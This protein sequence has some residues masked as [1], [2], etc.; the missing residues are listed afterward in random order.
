MP[1]VL[2]CLFLCIFCMLTK[3]IH[4]YYLLLCGNC[5]LVL[6]TYVFFINFMYY[7]YN[8][9]CFRLRHV[10]H[11][12][13]QNHPSLFNVHFIIV[14]SYN[15][16]FSPFQLFQLQ[17]FHLKVFSAVV[18]HVLSQ[19]LSVADNGALWMSRWG[20]C[21]LLRG[22]VDTVLDAPAYMQSCSPS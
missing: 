21:D 2:H 9:S 18:E 5:Y 15:F 16:T 20:C 17:S 6:S 1:I 12:N 19:F 7:R 4:Y 13:I 22:P 10:F 8:V 11:F 3:C 14:N